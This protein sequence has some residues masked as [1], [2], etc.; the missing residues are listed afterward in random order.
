MQQSAN[1]K[2]RGRLARFMYVC[3]GLFPPERPEKNVTTVELTDQEIETYA[4]VLR[5]LIQHE[6]AVQNYR[7]TWFSAFQALLFAATAAAWEKH[8][9]SP[10][11][12]LICI[13]G[14]VSARSSL[15]ALSL[16]D[17]AY[18]ELKG[19]WTTRIDRNGKYKGPERQGA[20]E[21]DGR[22]L[23]FMPS[24]ILPPLLIV[25]WIAVILIRLIC[26]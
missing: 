21:T 16:S 10:L 14:A 2:K 25:C 19:W 6:D 23:H 17:E 15:H 11:I 18:L 4:S 20:T 22:D 9:A 7:F 12:Y 5:G 3:F 26:M 13:V 8:G 24:R 1:T